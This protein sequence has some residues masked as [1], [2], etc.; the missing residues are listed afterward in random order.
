MARW[1]RVV[2]Q[3]PRDTVMADA[4]DATPPLALP[5]PSTPPTPQAPPPP[6][7]A[8][9][10]AS[11]APS[12]P[13][14]A[15]PAAID[16]PVSANPAGASTDTK[17]LARLIN[18]LHAFLTFTGVTLGVDLGTSAIKIVQLTQTKTGRTLTR[19]EIQPIPVDI[20]ANE[21]QR[22]AFIIAALKEI[23]ARDRLAHAQVMVALSG[24]GTSFNTLTVPKMGKKDL[25]GAIGLELKKT[26][27]FDI[28]Q[29]RWDYRVR[30]ELAD[31][32]GPKVEVVTV[33]SQRSV[34]KEV[35]TML[36]DAGLR[37]AGVT[38]TPC[39]LH[40]LLEYG[41]L[42]EPGEVA[43][44]LEIGA[45]FSSLTFSKEGSLQFSRDLPIGSDHLTQALVRTITLPQGRHDITAQEAEGIKRQLGIP[46]KDSLEQP[47]EGLGVTQILAMMRPVLERLLTELQRSLNYYRQ[48][49]RVQKISRLFLSG[50]GSRLQ[51]LNEFLAANLSG[52]R[53]ERL[54]LLS[55]I[56]GW[57]DPRASEHQ[58]LLERLAPHL[59]VAFGL[60]LDQRQGRFNLVPP[61]V[62][63]EERLA[64]ARLS[65]QVALPVAALL[66]FGFCTMLRA[67]P[68]Q[69]RNLIANTQA[70]I[71]ALAPQAQKIQLLDQM[72]QT[73]E[74]RKALLE[75]AVGRQ[76]LWTGMLKELGHITPEEIALTEIGVVPNTQPRRLR[77]AGEILPKFTSAEIA[78]AQYQISLEESPFFE[79]VKPITM[80]KDP[81]SVTTKATFELTVQ[82]TY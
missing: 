73:M 27:A 14:P 8:P 57:S 5:A 16:P 3:E 63:I 59:A 37:V 6:P 33:T 4:P 66:F 1:F 7:A 34:I 53:V 46:R 48:T 9:P 81:F 26:L 28:A 20:R 68:V 39:A 58:E 45:R 78:F 29:S 55:T 22:R 79:N 24:P 25:Q 77:I 31:R 67:Q 75:K 71:A 41:G 49:F 43:V 80:K 72:Q 65:A 32:A 12:A 56:H 36:G 40:N 52:I 17:G 82:L 35:V 62:K 44:V 51:H 60:A 69:Y 47:I 61:E 50:G 23:I 18:Q 64:L 70:Q 42:V 2:E 15:A 10:A 11:V 13:P 38:L 76:P 19:F 21:P 74:Q 30:E 54:D